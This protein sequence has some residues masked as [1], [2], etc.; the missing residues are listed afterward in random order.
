M[1]QNVLFEYDKINYY[2][3]Q[4]FS[5]CTSHDFQE[6]LFF[7]EYIFEFKEQFYFI[8]INNTIYFEFLVYVF[9][10]ISLIFYFI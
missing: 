1:E 6:F 2:M 4:S 8:F 7:K 9:Q 3:K 10:K 5:I